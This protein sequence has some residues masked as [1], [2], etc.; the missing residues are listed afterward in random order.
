MKTYLADPE[1]QVGI[2]ETAHPFFEVWLHCQRVFSVLLCLLFELFS[3]K[4][5][6]IVMTDALN[7]VLCMGPDKVGAFNKA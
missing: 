1:Y 3:D 2:T 7:S 5:L 4:T 6:H